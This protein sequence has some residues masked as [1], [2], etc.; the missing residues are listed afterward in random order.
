MEDGALSLSE[1]KEIQSDILKWICKRK[2]QN[3]KF[4]FCIGA[5]AKKSLHFDLISDFIKKLNKTSTNTW[6]AIVIGKEIDVNKFIYNV[7]FK[8]VLNQDF[9]RNHADF[10]YRVIDDFSMSYS[11][12]EAVHYKIPTITE[13][14]GILP[15]LI[16]KYKIGVVVNSFNEDF[17]EIENFKYKDSRFDAFEKENNW[18][19]AACKINK[20]Y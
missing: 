12:Y 5:P 15:H 10:Y 13:N 20:Y 2:D 19:V 1:N 11:T 8:Y 14:F 17:K 16:N 18:E 6:Y 3:S 7:P 9:I 4:I